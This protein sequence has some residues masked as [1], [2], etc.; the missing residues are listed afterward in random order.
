MNDGR[1]AVS[2]RGVLH[3]EASA[4]TYS[5]NNATPPVP[6]KPTTPAKTRTT[7]SPKPKPL[8]LQIDGLNVVIPAP[9][10]GN[11][12]PAYIES[13]ERGSD[14]SGDGR[15]LDLSASTVTDSLSSFPSSANGNS[16]STEFGNSHTLNGH[17]SI[18]W[19]DP[20]LLESQLA[21]H[22]Q[23]VNGGASV[24]RWQPSLS[25]IKAG[26]VSISPP[27]SPKHSRTRSNFDARLAP[28]QKRTAAGDFKSTL[29]PPTAH[30]ADANGA[31]RQRS[32]ST[33]SSAHG[34]RIA[35]VTRPL[36]PSG[37]IAHL[38]FPV[39]GPYPYTSIIRGCQSR[40]GPTVA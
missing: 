20:E 26:N 31:A 4:N 11:S 6:H 39:V 36:A 1:K 38:Y 16:Q 19:V 12:N 18:P 27:P 3:A 28:G 5:V 10:E 8:S 40:A 17:T 22:I 13:S 15:R 29:D 9:G 35:Q 34:S 32:K 30:S 14:T 25:P 23:P 37:I 21:P 2:N 33:G 24:D 7:Q